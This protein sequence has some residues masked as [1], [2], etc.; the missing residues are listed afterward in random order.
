MPKSRRT[1]SSQLG[2]SHIHDVT[3]SVPDTTELSAI[4]EP[5]MFVG[6]PQVKPHCDRPRHPRQANSRLSQTYKTAN[7]SLRQ[8]R[9]HILPTAPLCEDIITNTVSDPRIVKFLTGG[10]GGVRATMVWIMIVLSSTGILKPLSESD[11]GK[12]LQR[13][14]RTE[15]TVQSRW[16]ETDGSDGQPAIS[17]FVAFQTDGEYV[18]IR[19]RMRSACLL[20]LLWDLRSERRGSR[21]THTALE[22]ASSSVNSFKRFGPGDGPCLLSFTA[23]QWQG[24][25][26]GA[27]L[28]LVV[29][30]AQTRAF[31]APSIPSHIHNCI[32][33]HT[34]PRIL[35][36][37]SSLPILLCLA[38]S[39]QK[40]ARPRCGAG[41]QSKKQ[42][43]RGFR[44]ITWST[45]PQES[46]RTGPEMRVF[47][48]VRV[49]PNL[50]DPEMVSRT[51][52]QKQ[53][54][55]AE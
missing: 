9:Q 27:R 33:T 55:R 46:S 40:Q 50:G 22:T 16:D 14:S 52:W 30:P 2:L 25:E 39:K 21:V 35:I 3:T 1:A 13:V 44:L 32:H 28:M 11:A 36:L 18:S 42:T 24:V 34:H 47:I 15:E 29:F 4:P 20:P 7:Q 45:T 19:R 51:K 31:S 6:P 23:A 26:N 43:V 8:E 38:T 17:A 41:L 54:P 12:R 53:K 37:L 10:G 48:G 5:S 49:A